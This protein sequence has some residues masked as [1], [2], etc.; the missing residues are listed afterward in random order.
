MK[1]FSNG[2]CS[3]VHHSLFA[4]QHQQRAGKRQQN[5]LSTFLSAVDL[6]LL[7]LPLSGALA[8]VIFHDKLSSTREKEKNGASSTSKPSK[9]GEMCLN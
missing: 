2:V 4:Q 5:K 6:L 3:K 8:D 7:L 1:A 9:S